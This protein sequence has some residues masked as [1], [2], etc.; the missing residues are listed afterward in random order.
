MTS[1]QT[2]TVWLDAALRRVD[3]LETVAGGPADADPAALEAQCA[4]LEKRYQTVCQ[5][6]T[7]TT[8]WFTQ[9]AEAYE[10]AWKY[11]SL[12]AIGLSALL[13]VINIAAASA[14]SAL[15]AKPWLATAAAVLSVGM[16]ALTT[17]SS[18]RR[19][20]DRP[21]SVAEARDQFFR[22]TVFVETVWAVTSPA[23][24]GTHAAWRRGSALLLFAVEEESSLRTLFNNE[25]RRPPEPSGDKSVKPEGGG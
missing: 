13:S 3:H 10:R 23:L 8:A 17:L 7:L 11:S 21:A 24:T 20:R 16:S 4:A 25:Q 14:L 12:A 9:Q 5:R 19:W 1:V 15:W 22:L 2:S 6:L 18:T